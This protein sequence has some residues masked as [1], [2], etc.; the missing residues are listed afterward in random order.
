MFYYFSLLLGLIEAAPV[1]P[2]DLGKNTREMIALR[3]LEE[4]FGPTN[5]LRDVAP[6][7]SRVVFDLA[8]SCEDVLKHIVQEVKYGTYFLVSALLYEFWLPRK[9]LNSFLPFSHKSLQAEMY[10]VSYKYLSLS[11]L[12]FKSK[13]GWTRAVEMGCSP[14]IMHKRASLPKCALEQVKEEFLISLFPLQ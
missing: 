8:A 11:G 13:K 4:L 14:F 6:P 12:T 3:C 9:K 7:D 2:D 1:L 10:T 5:G